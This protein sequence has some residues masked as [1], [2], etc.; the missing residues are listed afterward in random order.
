M[1]RL[2]NAVLA[3]P[4]TMATEMR[5]GNAMGDVGPLSVAAAAQNLAILSLLSMVV[6]PGVAAFCAFAAI[7]SLFDTFYLLTFFLAVLNVDI[8]RL[9]LQDALA[10]R[11]NKP[12]HR[13]R[14]LPVH[15]SW[16]DALVQGRLPFR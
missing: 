14:P 12:R 15:H 3:Y 9:E 13:K 4:P 1:F 11:H 7:A 8:R 6:S 10:A 16:L 2:I 5:I